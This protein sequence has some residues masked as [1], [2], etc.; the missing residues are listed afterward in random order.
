[1]RT[2]SGWIQRPST[3]DRLDQFTLGWRAKEIDVLEHLAL[4]I[5]QLTADELPALHMLDSFHFHHLLLDLVQTIGLIKIKGDI[6]DEVISDPTDVV[7]QGNHA[8]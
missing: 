8:H 7:M 6:G 4:L 1:M 2:S 5:Q 3:S